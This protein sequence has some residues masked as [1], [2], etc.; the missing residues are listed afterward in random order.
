MH[1]GARFKREDFYPAGCDQQLAEF[2][3]LFHRYDYICKPLTNG[4]WFSANEK[5]ALT[6]TEILKAAACA[7]PKYFLGCRAGRA[8]RFAVLDIDAGSKYHNKAELHRLTE[9]LSIAGISKTSLYR[10]SYS[11]GWHLYIFFD[12][13][14]S[15][16]DLQKTLSTLL[17]L[18]KF[19]IAKGKLEIFPHPGDKSSKGQGLRLP[20]QSGF[21]WLN[22]K[23]LEVT[24]ERWELSAEKAVDYFLDD[25][26]NCSNTR[27]DFHRIKAHVERLLQSKAAVVD[28]VRMIERA[29]STDNVVPIRQTEPRNQTASAEIIVQAFGHWPNGMNPDIWLK[30][31]EYFQS[32]LTGPGQRADA[33]FC[34]GHYLFYG[35]PELARPAMG[36]GYEQERQWAI[37]QILLDRHHGYSKD[38]EKRA[39]DAFE[40][41]ERAANWLPPRRRGQEIIRYESKVPIAWRRN[42][43]NLK[44]DARKRISEALEGFMAAKTPFSVRDLARSSKCANDTL[45]RHADLWKHVQQQLRTGC[46]AGVPGEYNAGVGAAGLESLP[47]SDPSLKIAPPGLLA[48]RQIVFEIS[49]RNQRDKRERE[50]KINAIAGGAKDRWQEK[51][52]E[53]KDLDISITPTESVKMYMVLL[54]HLIATAPD[55]ETEDVVRQLYQKFQTVLERH[56]AGSFVNPS[57]SNIRKFV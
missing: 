52:S 11:D 32:G 26:S 43:A 54:S 10:S 22:D 46:F 29:P 16:R 50:K 3:S 8:S 55:K 15:S 17:V 56:L 45:Y 31:R 35:D 30:G 34:L 51:W 19:E 47:P 4:S 25:I 7:H 42:S 36:Y 21:A 44:L 2:T 39:S 40:Q 33:I 48:A 13:P 12:E 18:N 57:G 9:V 6:D 27:H 1:G 20:L 23:T 28:S 5:W 53:V 38:I 14:V 37:E 49:R 41:V 24:N